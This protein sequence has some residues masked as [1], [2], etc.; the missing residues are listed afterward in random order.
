LSEIAWNLNLWLM[1]LFLL[2]AGASAWYTLS[3]RSNR[4]Y[5]R[6]RLVH[7]GL[8]LL[9]L[10]LTFAVPATYLMQI[11]TGQFSS[12]LV[13]FYLHFFDSNLSLFHLWFLAYLL[14]YSL[15]TLPLF[16][17]LQSRAGR[18]L[19]DRLARVCQSMGGLY[20]FA[21]PLL[22]VQLA[23]YG[24]APQTLSL[25][26]SNDW[27]RFTSLLLEFIFGYILISEP[28]FQSAI[29]SQWKVALAVALAASALMFA[30]AWQDGFD[31]YRDLPTDYSW[32]YAAFWTVFVF[33]SWSWLIAWLGFGQRFLNVNRPL[34]KQATA[35]SFPLYL[36]HPMVVI[37]SA[38]V[39][40]QWTANGLVAALMLT[41]IVLAGTLALTAV[42]GRWRVARFMLGLK[43]GSASSQVFALRQKDPA[44]WPR[45]LLALGSRRRPMP[46]P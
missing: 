6:E 11:W 10:V 17:F 25:V 39:V 5:L 12:S 4:Q 36:L 35:A 30:I 45:R 46:L 2:L 26:L 18:R 1:P 19:I 38:L 32:R 33:G 21:L 31:P 14:I 9:I 22:I 16:R 13:V 7:L 3:K 37:P 24:L 28:R 41:T 23:L 40:T 8:P 44:R 29:A 20:V 34:L 43:T 15:V 42:L 27:T